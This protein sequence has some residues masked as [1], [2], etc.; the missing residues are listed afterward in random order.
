MRHSTITL[1]MD[2]YGHLLPDQHA[3][4]VGGMMKMLAEDMPLAATGTAGTREKYPPSVQR[5]VG[6]PYDAISCDTERQGDEDADTRQTLEFPRKS[7]DDKV[8]IEVP[9][10]GFEPLTGGL[11]IRCSIQL[12][13]GGV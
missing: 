2:T 9:P 7:E 1:T 11:E 5:T 4:A 8:E 10:R 6:L 3:D 13:Y 12:S